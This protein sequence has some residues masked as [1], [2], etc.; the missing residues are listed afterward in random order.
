MGTPFADA[1]LAAYRAVLKGA[2]QLL[3]E[4]PE[5][6]EHVDIRSFDPEHP[7]ALSEDERRHHMALMNTLNDLLSIKTTA[8]SARFMPA[9]E[10]L[11]MLNGLDALKCEF[12][13]QPFWPE[14]AV[15]QVWE[16]LSEFVDVT[17]RPATEDDEAIARALDA[18]LNGGEGAPD[19]VASWNDAEIARAL[20]A[21]MNGGAAAAP[22]DDELAAA[23]LHAK[24]NDGA[25][26]N[27]AAIAAAMGSIGIDHPAESDEDL[28]LRLA[29][30]EERA[31][32]RTLRCPYA[33]CR[34]PIE[35]TETACRVATCGRRRDNGAQLPQHD[36][37]GARA[38]PPGSVIGCRRQFR[39]IGD[40][41]SMRLEPCTGQ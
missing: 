7:R 6:F 13:D 30:E 3:W 27:D 10:I 35:I 36:E 17:I 8:L 5:R 18:E 24:L 4:H 22:A 12:G 9:P 23:L 20:D 38:M 26:A 34:C 2:A 31:E 15:E 40:G 11:R 33:D 37:A 28:A 14:V 32:R 41:D 29:R 1:Q 21:E 16:Q 19:M 39:I 25:V